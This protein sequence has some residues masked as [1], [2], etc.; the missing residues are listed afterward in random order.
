[1][2]ECSVFNGTI[3]GASGNLPVEPWAS[4][5]RLIQN[6]PSPIVEWSATVQFT[7]VDRFLPLQ[8]QVVRVR[9]APNR[10]FDYAG[11]V[12]AHQ[13][14]PQSTNQPEFLRSDQYGYIHLSGHR[15]GLNHVVDAYAE[16]GSVAAVT[17]RFPTLS[18]EEVA[19]V[20]NFYRKNQAEVDILLAKQREEL[21][22]QASSQSCVPKRE[23]LRRRMQARELAEKAV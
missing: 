5:L 4:A 18:G 12:T 3:P 8:L 1:V 23:E 6:Q 9:A 7:Q 13:A 21:E 14:R 17:E 2:V 20:I 15:I 11:R 16:L 19:Q 22:R 10:L